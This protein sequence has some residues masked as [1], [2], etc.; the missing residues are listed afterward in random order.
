MITG[1]R[2]WEASESRYY[3]AEAKAQPEELRRG[4]SRQEARW[5]ESPKFILG[6]PGESAPQQEEIPVPY[7]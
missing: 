7:R 6:E 2:V 1:N 5:S 4:E 3:T